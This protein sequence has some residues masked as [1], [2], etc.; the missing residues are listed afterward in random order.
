MRNPDRQTRFRFKQFE[1]SNSR[2]AMKIGTDGVLLGAWAID[3]LVSHQSDNEPRV[4]DVGSGTG[5]IALML[6]QR[7]PKALITGIECDVDAAEEGAENFAG[8]PWRNNLQMVYA[9]FNTNALEFMP[10][11]FDAVVSNPPFFTNGAHAPDVQRLTARHEGSLNLESLTAGAAR[12]LR[13]GGILSIV[14]PMEQRQRAEFVASMHRLHAIRI[15]EVHTVASKPARRV[16][17]DFIKDQQPTMVERTTLCI[18]D[19]DGNKTSD[20]INLVSPFYIRL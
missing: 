19:A 5:L 9:D 6:A 7:F 20:Y 16:L 8:S 18:S 2:S 1:M 15:C 11:S 4:M 12:L 3:A 17:I 10:E 14:I 13:S